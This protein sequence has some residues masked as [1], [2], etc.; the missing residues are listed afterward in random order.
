M[1][2]PLNVGLIGFGNWARKAYA[3]VL[4]EMASVHVAAVA[5]RSHASREEA[6][7]TFGPDITTYTDFHALIQAGNVDAVMVALPGALHADAVEAAVKAG[8]HVFFEPPIA[9]TRE[10]TGVALETIGAASSVVQADFELRY[11]PVMDAVVDLIGRDAIGAVRLAR[12]SLWCDW[13]R[14]GELSSLAEEGIAFGLGPWYLDALDAVV[15]DTPSEAQVTGGYARNGRFLD[16]GWVALRYD[17]GAVGCFEVNL[18]APKGDG[19]YLRVVGD[20][21]EIEANLIS[22]D[23]RR[24]GA[25]GNW[26]DGSAPPSLPKCGFVGM[27]ECIRDFVDAVTRRR[28]SRT[29]PDVMR[30]VHEAMLLCAE[31]ERG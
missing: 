5:A 24:R 22:G 9:L 29:T 25:D 16:H 18:L 6:R 28:A 2:E 14:Q 23:Y 8:K 1:S 26:M 19:I 4:R 11:L 15:A 7:K 13:G 10:A 20:T 30:R 21:G 3:P 17:A 31:A 12:V 27:R